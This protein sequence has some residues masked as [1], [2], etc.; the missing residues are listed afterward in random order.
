MANKHDL[1]RNEPVVNKVSIICILASKSNWQIFFPFSAVEHIP[2]E[3]RKEVWTFV[4]Q[5]CQQR[6]HSANV[7]IKVQCTDSVL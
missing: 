6:H 4:V 1:I 3:E 2:R 7:G 5:E